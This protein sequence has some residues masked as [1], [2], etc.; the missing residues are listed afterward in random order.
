MGDT[1]VLLPAP[2]QLVLGV[3]VQDTLSVFGHNLINKP[4]YVDSFA[5]TD[6]TDFASFMH[7]S[8]ATFGGGGIGN[9]QL[10][11]LGNRTHAQ[12]CL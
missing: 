6:Q 5:S 9:H 10:F 3:P 4:E 12:Q 7:C 2:P 8:G 11:T 1:S